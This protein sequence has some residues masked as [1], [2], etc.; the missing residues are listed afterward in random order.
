MKAKWITPVV[1]ALDENG[2][3]DTEANK[4]IYEHLIQ[5]GIDGILIF[6]SIGEFFALPMEEKKD[7]VRE[8]VACIDHRVT[9]YI[10]TNSMEF[11]ECVEFSNFAL[12][13]G[14]DGVMVISPY[15]FNLPDSAVENFYDSLADRVN[16]PVLLYNFPA[17]TGYDLK[18]EVILGLVRR[19]KNIVGI[20]DTVGTMGHTRA[21]IQAVKREFPEFLVY[22][23]F[24]EF[25]AHNVL[26]GGDGCIAGLS[27]FAPAVAAGFAGAARDNDLAA[28][29]AYQQKID[30]LMAIYDVAEQFIPIIK[31]A[32]V[33]C[34]VEMDPACAAPLLSA[35]ENE[36]E[37]I[38]EI[39]K[40]AEII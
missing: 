26:S 1:T 39:L 30:S 33:L 40:Q 32:M 12:D 27:N 18:P 25:F 21:I 6:G 5:G 22:S 7:M 11:E 17:R 14:A 24:D 37:K 28:M 31:K 15:Y 9:V 19:H 34:G 35:D 36:T 23:G 8:A 38:R 13:A 4:R 29:Q 10:G 2:H 3:I 20:K 16:G